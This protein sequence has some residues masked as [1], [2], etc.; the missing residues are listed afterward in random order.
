MAD[1]RFFNNLGPF[2]LARI[3]EKAGI[4]VP[5]GAEAGREFF[6]LADLAGSDSR[7]LTFFSGNFSLREAFAASRAGA[8]LVPAKGKRPEAPKGMIV[9]EAASVSHA[10]A[11][12]A[13]MFYPEHSQPLWPRDAPAISPQARIGRDVTLAPG[14]VVGADAEI[15]EGTRIGPG[16]VIGPGVAIGR[17]CEI[18]ANVSI[19]H[20]YVGDR[21]IILPGAQLGQPGFGFASS[22]AGHIKMPQL[23][24]VIVQDDVEIGSC[25]TIDRGALRDTVIGEGTKLD[26]LIMIGHN[27]RIGRHCVLAGQVGIAGSCV[28]GDFVVMGGQVGLGDHTHVGSHARMAARSGTGSGIVLPGGID[29][30]GAPAKPVREW[31]REIHAVARLGKQ[32]RQNKDE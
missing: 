24:R 11:A 15:G 25:T 31:A 8:C 12:V 2:T 7:H 9:L 22:D 5:N 16:T 21:V 26:N 29:Y 6:D 19:S 3:C 18:G 13:A 32:R 20:A 27:C 1:P 28:V 4:A 10:F 30:G 14:V 17:H 23:G